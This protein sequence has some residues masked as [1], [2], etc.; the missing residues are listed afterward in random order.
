MILSTFSCL[1]TICITSWSA[2]D[3]LPSFPILL[4]SFCSWVLRVLYKVWVSSPCQIHSMQAIFLSLCLYSVVLFAKA[5]NLNV[6]LLSVFG[7]VCFRTFQESSTI[8]CSE[9]FHM[10]LSSCLI[11]SG[12]T[13]KSFDNFELVFIEQWRRIL[14]TMAILELVSKLWMSPGKDIKF[15]QIQ[16]FDQ[17]WSYAQNDITG[18]ST[19]CMMPL[20]KQQPPKKQKQLKTK[21]PK[22]KDATEDLQPHL[23]LSWNENGLVH[24]SNSFTEKT[25]KIFNGHSLFSTATEQW[26]LTGTAQLFQGPWT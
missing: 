13:L 21:S 12:L 24:S 6:T 22:P 18:H 5:F 20:R 17:W 3:L 15:S 11:V 2:V 26:L 19:M 25:S 9:V 23:F 7:F 8:Q 4:V 16:C 14:S 10:L 1:L